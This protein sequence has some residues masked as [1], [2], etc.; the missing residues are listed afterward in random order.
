MG[1]RQWK[2]RVQV[3]RNQEILPELG[4]ECLDSRGGVQHVAVVGHFASEVSDFGGDDFSAVGCRL[5]RRDYA[6]AFFEFVC[7]PFQA[8]L[9]IVEAIDGA[10][11]F[12]A[13]A[14]FP[15]QKGSVSC[16]LV[17]FAVVFFAAVRK[18]AVVVTDKVTVL[19]VSQLFGDF[20]GTL[21]V[22]KHEYQVFFLGVLVLAEQGI[23]EYAGSEFLV[24]R[25]DKGDQVPE[26]EQFENQNVRFG[27][28]EYIQHVLHG[29]FVYK[30]F[31][32]VNVPDE[33][34]ER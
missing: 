30:A 12:S 33:N 17:N 16:N 32:S 7:G 34:A 26:H 1:E 8:F 23:D 14:D 9:K 25:T 13:V 2:F 5:E 10:G 21:H 31:A 19:D 3:F 27:L 20:G 22:D 24:D 11:L 4:A 18:Q 6:V 29:S 28:L 15:G